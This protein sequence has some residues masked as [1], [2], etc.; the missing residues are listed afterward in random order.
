MIIGIPVFFIFFFVV[1]GG[2]F[3]LSSPGSLF[4]AEAIQVQKIA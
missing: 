3:C 1:V 4:L 2:W